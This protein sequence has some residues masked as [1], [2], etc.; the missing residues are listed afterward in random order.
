MEA[1]KT[2]LPHATPRKKMGVKKKLTPNKLQIAAPC[3]ASPA[4]N[5]RSKQKIDM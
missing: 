2:V 5:T 4:S 1:P 3:P